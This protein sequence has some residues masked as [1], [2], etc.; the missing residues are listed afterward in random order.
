LDSYNAV[1][2]LN[3]KVAETRRYLGILPPV[4]LERGISTVEW[5]YEPLSLR[6]GATVSSMTV[7][8]LSLL[9]LTPILRRFFVRAKRQT[10][11]QDSRLGSCCHQQPK[12]VL[13]AGRPCV[14]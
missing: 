3:G 7:V 14:I 10:V 13:R 4:H 8:L 11:C 1:V 2:Y 6:I 12:A 5:R 9:C